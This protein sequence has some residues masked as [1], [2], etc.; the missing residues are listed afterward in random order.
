MCKIFT[1]NCKM[2]S[3][4][5]FCISYG[6]SYSY[7]FGEGVREFHIYQNTK[8]LPQLHIAK[9]S[10]RQRTKNKNQKKKPA[11]VSIS[12]WSPV[13]TQDPSSLE[14]SKIQSVL[15]CLSVI[16][17]TFVLWP[18]P[19]R[20]MPYHYVT[21]LLFIVRRSFAVEEDRQAPRNFRHYFIVG[22]TW[23]STVGF[24]LQIA[25]LWLGYIFFTNFFFGRLQAALFFGIKEN[26]GAPPVC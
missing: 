14:S 21:S 13:S 15:I 20:I 12:L 1:T 4:R 18:I 10:V 24:Y 8:N 2:H 23:W 22:L 26:E 11:T 7:S 25:V 17:Y 6:Y 9:T 3:K 5:M 19:V 16:V